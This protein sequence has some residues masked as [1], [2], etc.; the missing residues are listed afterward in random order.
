MG[1]GGAGGGSGGSGSAWAVA[2]D[3]ATPTR[4]ITVI[5]AVLVDHIVARVIDARVVAKAG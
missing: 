3:V 1:A 5:A 2:A 4:T